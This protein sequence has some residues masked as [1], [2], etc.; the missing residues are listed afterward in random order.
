[1]RAAWLAGPLL[2]GCVLAAHA[3]EVGPLPVPE[4]EAGGVATIVARI[5]APEGVDSAAYDVRLEP[6]YQSFAPLQGRV[7]RLDDH[8]IL[9]LTLATPARLPAGRVVAGTLSVRIAGLPTLVRDIVLEVRTQRRVTLRLEGDELTVAPDAVV[10]I[11]YTLQNSGNVADTVYLDVQAGSGWSQLDAPRTVLQPGETVQGRLR[12]EAPASAAPGDRRV[13]LVTA[14]SGS[15]ETTQTV[16]VVVVSP[17]GWLGSL[18]HVPSSLFVG[19]STLDGSGPVVALSGAG[20]IGPDTRVQLDLRHGDEV[21]DP[22]LQRRIAGARLRAA[23]TRPDLQIEA[24]DVYGFETTLSGS[25]RQARGVRGQFDPAGPLAFRGLVALPATLNGVQG[26]HLIHGETELAT[27]YGGI[28]VLAGDNL[29]P[30]RSTLPATRSTGTGLRWTTVRGAHETSVEATAFRFSAADSLRR[31][32]AAVDVRYGLE[33]EGVTGRIRLRRVPDAVASPGG[34]GNELSASVSARLA[35]E[36]YLVAWGYDID[37]NYLGSGSRNTS[38]AA[39]AGARATLG[40][41]QLQVGGTFSDRSVTSEVGTI[42][43]SRATGRL[44]GLYT[45]GALTFQSDVEIGRYGDGGGTGPYRAIGATVRAHGRDRWGWLRVQHT[46]RPGDLKSLT[47]NGGGT[48]AIGP[49]ELSGGVTVGS[50]IGGVS[51]TFWSGA[52]IEARRNLSVHIGA[53]ARPGSTGS[54][55]AFSLGVSRRLSLPLPLVRQPDLSGVI[56]ED[57]NANGAR[58]PGEPAVP[59][60]QLTLGYLATRSDADGRFA[61]RDAPG[62]HLRLNSADLPL[63]LVV[64][65]GTSLPDRG[66]AIIPLVRTATLTLHLFLDRDEDGERDPAETVGASASVTL[67]NGEGWERTVVADDQGHVRITGLL[68]GH[69]AIT[70]RPAGTPEREHATD[71][72]VLMEVE[73][74]PG[75]ERA[76]TLAVPL[77]RRTIRMGGDGGGFQFFENR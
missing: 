9:P 46:V 22:V 6:G 8:F 2:L 49:V 53:S 33:T 17:A 21:A 59:G 60:V 31:T 68:P 3:Q 51:T 57:R 15:G 30:G 58:D 74:G 19:Q 67:S 72:E 12:L 54:E 10:P 52:E 32:G 65:P 43:L 71:A 27:R 40:D 13:M 11:L 66:E 64:S 38:R 56:F 70:A 73:L 39:T 37:Q 36:L 16:D 1:M 55:W 62:E 29:R 34:Q 75:E 44:E 47:F 77:R 69:Y 76:D 7:V 28:A 23:V 5:P 20:T 63:G 41:F 45:R 42:D 18:A 50:Y 35:P 14:R 25:I 48:A 24:G 4:V 61:F 26:G